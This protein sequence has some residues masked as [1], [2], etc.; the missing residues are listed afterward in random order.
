MV[1][2]AKP[3][4][5]DAEAR[6]E[7]ILRDR[8][9]NYPQGSVAIERLGELLRGARR[10]RM[11]SLLIF[12]EPDI[13]KTTILKKFMRGHD[14]TID[15]QTGRKKA[16]VIAFEAPP[17]ADERRLYAA[18]LRAIG[19]PI[20]RGQVVELE[21][22]TYAQLERLDTRLLVIDETN[23]LTIGSATAQRR[24]LAA[25]RRLANQLALSFAFLGTAEALNAVMSDPQVEGRSQPF[26]LT[27]LR[28]DADY[29]AIVQAV[30]AYLPLQRPSLCD[31]SMVA[32]VHDLTAG[33]PGKTFRLLNAAA[34]RAIDDAS[35][36]I[37]ID[38]L[39]SAVVTRHILTA[40]MMRRGAKTDVG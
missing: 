12:G 20:P 3:S 28:N 25:L 7:L 14:A 30:I 1:V 34:V 15:E 6:V 11:P 19:A 31:S 16:D 21:S 39:R 10:T 27:R 5:S 37:T 24:T 35:E 18:I 22:A 8:W 2:A 38:L 26:K 13:G 23:N 17:E 40:G 4:G 36:Q 9:V 32:A 29:A 33:S